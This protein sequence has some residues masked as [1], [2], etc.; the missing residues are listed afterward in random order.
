MKRKLAVLFFLCAALACADSSQCIVVVVGFSG[1]GSTVVCLPATALALPPGPAGPVGPQGAAGAKG[2]QGPQGAQGTQGP[3]GPTGPQGPAGPGSTG[4]AC[5]VPA[6]SSPTL[7]VKL[8]DG[9]CLP[10][11][12]VTPTATNVGPVCRLNPDATAWENQASCWA[13]DQH[14]DGTYTLYVGA[15]DSRVRT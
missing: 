2:D 6:G 9:T 13:V 12:L 15:L 7:M 11:V 14:E 5:T 4:Q 8:P 3:A 10:L 1:G